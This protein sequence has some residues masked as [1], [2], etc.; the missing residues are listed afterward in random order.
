LKW[1]EGNIQSRG[2]DKPHFMEESTTNL[3]P[4]TTRFYIRI[5]TNTLFKTVNKNS[6]TQERKRVAR[7]F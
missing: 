7:K 6:L 4:F 1:G 5:T 3:S 2:I